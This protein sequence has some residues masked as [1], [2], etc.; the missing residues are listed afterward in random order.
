MSSSPSPS[1]MLGGIADR[2]RELHG[3]DSWNG[4]LDPLDL[5]L[6]ASIISYGELVQ[7]TYDSFNRERRSPH[8]GACIYGHDDLLAMTGVSAPG[9]YRITKFVYATSGLP[10]PDAFVLLPLPS[11]AP[12]AWSK[13]S[14][15]MGYVAVA[16]DEGVAAL[17]R[18]D[19]VVAWRGTVKNLEWVNDFDFTPVSA[20]PVLGS[21]AAANPLA[22]VHR[23]FLSVY[24]SS[25][26]NS[27]YNQASARD[28]VLE[29]V[30]RLMQLYKD[31]V[32][33]I[34]ITGHSLGASLATLNAVDIVANGVNCSPVDSSQPPCPVTAIV[35]ASP[36][37]GDCHFKA[38]FAS[39]SDLR[40]LHVKNAGDV[41]PL[42]PPLGYVDVA[43]RLP[44]STSRSPFLRSL[45]TV[46]TLHNLE[47]YLHGV[48]GEQ[49]SAGG[50]KLEVD[51]DVALVNKSVDALK[52][53]YPVPAEWWVAKNRC[54]VK[55][56]DGHWALQDFKQI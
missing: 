26:T 38:A 28:Q 53:K 2:W 44:I 41:V 29:E 1:P 12:A 40:A 55:G 5:D 7:A 13:E 39:F 33:S 25:D 42:Y 43:V 56:A 23:G 11:L 48:A 35:F 21:T 46:E 4:L 17:G 20:A 31:E 9:N 52:D 32:N 16:T 37:V 22:I 45:G 19:I 30:R 18:R 6:R 24:R 47:C 34:T 8:A 36:R 51:R 15:W 49:G 54:M 14:N 3:E 50:F 10:V 27:K